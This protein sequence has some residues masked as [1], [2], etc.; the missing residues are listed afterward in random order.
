MATP[1]A[2]LLRNAFLASLAAFY[3]SWS[4]PWMGLSIVVG[5]GMVWSVPV[6]IVF[7]R[8]QL[9]AR[10]QPLPSGD[11]ASLAHETG[12]TAEMI[13]TRLVHEAVVGAEGNVIHLPEDL[14]DSLTGI[15][16]IHAECEPC[17]VLLRSLCE[18]SSSV[19]KSPLIVS[20]RSFSSTE[21]PPEVMLAVDETFDVGRLLGAWQAPA[22]FVPSLPASQ[23]GDYF[24]QGHEDVAVLL[25]QRRY[26]DVATE[27]A[28]P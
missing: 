12:T 19:N 23:S 18:I 4:P 24:A 20:S 25:N 13:R 5:L 6:L 27:L 10:R 1:G 9:V 17:I 2:A 7:L 11:V 22:V 8:L 15:L 16:C 28:A 21:L 3:L 26:S 14:Q